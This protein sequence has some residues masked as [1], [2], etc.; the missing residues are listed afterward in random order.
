MGLLGPAGRNPAAVAV[1]ASAAGGS[2]SGA[3]ASVVSQEAASSSVSLAAAAHAP[4]T[5]TTT[6]AATEPSLSLFP[7]RALQYDV[8][9]VDSKVCKQ[10]SKP[11]PIV[12]SFLRQCGEQLLGVLP[13]RLRTFRASVADPSITWPQLP[14]LVTPAVAAELLRACDRYYDAICQ[15]QVWRERVLQFHVTAWFA[16]RGQDELPRCRGRAIP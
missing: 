8:T 14:L 16:R 5:P 12:V 13:R 10:A 3:G 15:L 6:T 9:E 7:P 4:T 2:G 1:P 11:L